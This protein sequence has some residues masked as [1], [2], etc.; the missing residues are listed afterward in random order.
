MLYLQTI[1]KRDDSEITKKIYKTQILKPTHGDFSELVQKD[2][3]MIEEPFDE[4]KVCNMSKEKFKRLV[5]VKIRKAA[6]DH[7]IKLKNTHSKVKDIKYQKLETQTYMKSSIFSNEEVNILH[8]LRS[9][10]VN[11]KINYRN[12]Y[13]EDDLLCKLCVAKTCTQEHIMQCKVIQEGFKTEEISQ[14]KVLYSDIFHSDVRKQKTIA[15]LYKYL[16]EIRTKMLQNLPQKQS[17]STP[18]RMLRK[19]VCIQPSI[20]Y[21]SVGK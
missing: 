11:C 17:P 8:A 14:G 20:M 15:T 7:L 5:K 4:T 1:L 13:R 9:R 3:K 10:S 18:T 16:L 2:F 19:S 12:L 21:S 6:F